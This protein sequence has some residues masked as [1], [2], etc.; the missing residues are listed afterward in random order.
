MT[1][2][3]RRGVL[4]LLSSIPLFVAW[5]S[6]KAPATNQLT[7]F[8]QPIEFDEVRPHGFNS[9]PLGPTFEMTEADIDELAALGNDVNCRTVPDPYGFCNGEPVPMG[10]R[11]GRMVELDPK[12]YGVVVIRT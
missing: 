8:E 1:S 4:K 10:I 6:S 11:N 9:V 5:R 7:A 3:T 12:K 2:L